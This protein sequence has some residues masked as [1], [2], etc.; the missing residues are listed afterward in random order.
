MSHAMGTV[1]VGGEPVGFFEYDGTA[2]VVSNRIIRAT[3][4]EVWQHWSKPAPPEHRYCGCVGV[5]AE[6]HAAYG[7][8]LTWDAVV[9][10]EHKRIHGPITPYP[11]DNPSE[12]DW[13]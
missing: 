9:C 11:A 8:G 4:A 6:L 5:T 7:R 2:D 10:L 13:P 3:H 1:L 12:E